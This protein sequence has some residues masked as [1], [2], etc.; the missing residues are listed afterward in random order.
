MVIRSDLSDVRHAQ[1]EVLREVARRGYGESACFAIRL[2]VEE[3]LNNAVKHGNGLDPN[4]CVTVCYDVDDT[5]AEVTV[6]DQGAGFDPE[7]IP[8]PT[9][10]ENLEKP[11]GRGIM[12]MRAYMDEVHFNEAGNQVRM[13]KVK[14]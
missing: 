11:C 2:A 12:L 3:A 6:A 7:D 4:K 10:D 13:V 8:D 9:A 5:A 14:E 1:R